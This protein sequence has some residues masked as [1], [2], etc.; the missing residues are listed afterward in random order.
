MYITTL[1]TQAGRIYPQMEATVVA[2]AF[3]LPSRGALTPVVVTGAPHALTGESGNS[4]GIF[5]LSDPA[6]GFW[7]AWRLQV[8]LK[9][10]P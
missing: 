9:D 2:G 8:A 3:Y 5:G 10:A 7:G 6:I 4:G 1:S